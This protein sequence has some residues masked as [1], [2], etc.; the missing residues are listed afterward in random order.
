VDDY[1][2]CKQNYTLLSEMVSFL[3]RTFPSICA[4]RLSYPRLQGGA[5][6]NVSRIVAP[7]WEVAPFVREAINRGVE[8]DVHVETE[9]IPICLLGTRYDNAD[10]LCKA[11]HN[12][13]DLTYSDSNYYRR[14]G[15]VF[16]DVCGECDVLNH[17]CGLDTLHHEVF[18]ESS[19]FR[20]VSFAGPAL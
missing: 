11:R 5:A 2:I 12:L 14:P 19:C 9:F 18:G 10:V 7:V 17:C 8:I 15:A 13:S 4:I 3:R 1:V 20:A 6:D 16:Y